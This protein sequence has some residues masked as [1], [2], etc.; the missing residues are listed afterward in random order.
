[1]QP[2][3]NFLSRMSHDMRTP[4]N[5]IVGLLKIDED[6]FEDQELVK[7]NHKKMQIS[8]DHLL[9][10]INDVLQMSKIED[11]TVSLT[12]ECIDLNKLFEEIVTIIRGKAL[13][14]GISWESEKEKSAVSYPYV[15]GSPLH[16]RQIFLNI[17]GNCI[18]YNRPGGK[19]STR[20]E[21]LEEHDGI[22]TYR[23]TISDTGVGMSREFLEHIYEPFFQ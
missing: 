9:S 13:E 17:Y 1:M 12:H 20:V 11:G 3:N 14:A 23:W 21:T 6:H 19:V 8:A 18:K 10:L 5:G 4:I 7:E 2:K 16:L 15:Y 22:C